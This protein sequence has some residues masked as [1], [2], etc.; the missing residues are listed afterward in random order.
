MKPQAS[1]G[2]AALG[3]F[4]SNGDGKIDAQ[5][6][7]FTDL[8][9]WVD[10]N[11]NGITDPGELFTLSQ[12]GV[13]SI[14]LTVTADGQ[15]QASNKVMADGHFTYEE[16]TVG[17]FSEVKL[18]YKDV[19][20]LSPHD[21][22][23]DHEDILELSPHDLIHDH[24]TILELTE[25]DRIVDVAQNLVHLH[26]LGPVDQGTWQELMGHE[27]MAV[28][29]PDNATLPHDIGQRLLGVLGLVP[30]SDLLHELLNTP[31]QPSLPVSTDH[32]LIQIPL[33]HQI[34]DIAL[35]SILP[36]PPEAPHAAD[37]MSGLGGISNAEILHH[38][39]PLEHPNAQH[40]C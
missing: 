21:L 18:S 11:H 24:N 27:A 23:H 38:L 30:G 32:S 35:S 26:I 36:P 25:A 10:S 19:L 9:L 15:W 3:T 1:S 13:A 33:L 22:I 5:D 7:Q 17:N 2:V 28:A 14:E 6:S 29:T 20:E 40:P 39:L 12:K 37:S 8:Q 4:D 16:G 34:L 31:E